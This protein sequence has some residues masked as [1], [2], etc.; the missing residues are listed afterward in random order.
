MTYVAV[1]HQGARVSVVM[2]P[3]GSGP[4]RVWILQ[5]DGWLPEDA[6]DEDVRVDA[7]GASYIDVTAPR[8]YWVARGRGEH[9]IRLSPEDAG[10]TLHA[11]A[12]EPSGV[13]PGRTEP[14]A[15]GDFGARARH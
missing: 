1:R 9:V 15:A 14:G 12:F 11:F 6:R 7:R 4:V 3:P 13:E 8:L 5:D 10:V 2:S